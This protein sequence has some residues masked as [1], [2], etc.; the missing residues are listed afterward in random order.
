MKKNKVMRLSSGLLVLTILTT[1]IISGTF[2]K[3][4]TGDKEQDF[5]RA[6]KWGVTTTISGALFGQH[7]GAFE[8]DSEGTEVDG[9]NQISAAY[10]GSVDRTAGGV[11][12]T[13]ENIVAPGT[14]SENMT[15]SIS[16]TPEV[17]GKIAVTVDD[18]EGK[19]YSD[20]W[21]ASGK[22]GV[23]TDVTETVKTSDDIVGLYVKEDN[24]ENYVA[25]KSFTEGT[26]YY[27]LSYD[28]VLDSEAYYG[29]T[30][31]DVPRFVSTN[32]ANPDDKTGK[33][34][35]ILWGLAN[36]KSGNDFG[37]VD[38]S[39]QSVHDIK[40]MIEKQFTGKDGEEEYSFSSHTDL[41]A[42]VGNTT[43]NWQWPFEALD[44]ETGEISSIIVDGCDTILSKLM[45]WE[46]NS[47]YQVVKI[48]GTEAAPTYTG[49]T[50]TGP[51][52][53]DPDAV[54]YAVVGTEQVAC[55]TVGFNLEVTVSQVD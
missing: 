26:T 54:T 7:Y 51:T 46:A 30:E 42:Q 33:Y 12:D 49:V 25:A 29:T 20:I 40:A 50:K 21:L 23:M 2:A 37:D 1:C 35:P 19:N 39:I 38:Y 16:G 34:Y 53:D 11:A 28:F 5:A 43:I 55:L 27:K 14:K 10:T 44:A 24:S 47:N 15:V 17:A 18:T 32:A 13:G 31:E 8:A 22:Y 36:K 6:A 3:Y 45:A 48:S 41:G 9:S 4:V 52:E